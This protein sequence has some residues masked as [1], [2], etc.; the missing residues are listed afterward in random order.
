MI[1]E[2]YGQMNLYFVLSFADSNLIGYTMKCNNDETY[3][4]N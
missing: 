3:Q 4:F 1:D 2:L